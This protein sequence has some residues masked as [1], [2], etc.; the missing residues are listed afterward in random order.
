MAAG[1]NQPGENQPNEPDFFIHTQD[2]EIV[3]MSDDLV[4]ESS[5]FLQST[6]AYAYAV[7]MDLIPNQQV[8][9]IDRSLEARIGAVSVSFAMGIVKFISFLH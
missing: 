2:P 3:A 5:T 8:S 6:E 1:E 7:R 4:H 9:G